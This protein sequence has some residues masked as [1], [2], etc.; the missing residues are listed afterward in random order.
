MLRIWAKAGHF[1][2]SSEKKTIP[3]EYAFVESLIDKSLETDSE[4]FSFHSNAASDV[5]EGY[6]EDLE[7][8]LTEYLHSCSDGYSTPGLSES[9]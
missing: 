1:G 9:D 8:A 6:R 7:A 3:I 2:I 5:G 4:Y